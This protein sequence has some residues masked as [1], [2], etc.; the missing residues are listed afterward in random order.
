MDSSERCA[1]IGCSS[2][3]AGSYLYATRVAATQFAVCDLHLAQLIAGSR[4]VVTESGD[5]NHPRLLLRHERS[6]Q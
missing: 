4:P 2:R 3:A 6:G 1:V 5:G